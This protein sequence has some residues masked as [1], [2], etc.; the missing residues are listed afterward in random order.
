MGDQGTWGISRN[1]TSSKCMARGSSLLPYK[2]SVLPGSSV[3]IHYLRLLKS[4]Q[5]PGCWL[6][7]VGRHG[8]VYPDMGTVVN[9]CPASK[10]DVAFTL[11][12]DRRA[13]CTQHST[14]GGFGPGLGSVTGIS[15]G[16]GVGRWCEGCSFLENMSLLL[17]CHQP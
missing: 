14:P 4:L 6:C 10:R 11:V 9:G 13:P 16:V 2:F 12:A 5:H 3:L 8:V 7:T 17:T 15:C 1:P